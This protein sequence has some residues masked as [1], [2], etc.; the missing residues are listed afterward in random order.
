MGRQSAR[1]LNNK[2]DHKDIFFNGNYHTQMWVTD[3]EANPTLVWEKIQGEVYKGLEL[4]AYVNYSNSVFMFQAK[5]NF[6]VNWGDGTVE[7]FN[8]TSLS[9]II[10]PYSIRAGQN[11]YYD[12]LV[13][14]DI[15]DLSFQSASRLSAVKN[16]LPPTLEKTDFTSMFSYLNTIDLTVNAD[17]FKYCGDVLIFDNCFYNSRLTDI[18]EGLFENCISAK[19]AKGCFQS[20]KITSIPDNFFSNLLGI[21]NLDSCFYG[22]S[23]LETVGTNV[24]KSCN[25]LKSIVNIFGFT[26]ITSLEEGIFDDLEELENAQK[27][28]FQCTKLESIPY[29]L[30][31][32]CKKLNDVYYAFYNCSAI[33]SKVPPLWEREWESINKYYGCYY[34]CTNAEN[35]NDIPWI[36]WS[37]EDN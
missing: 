32:K 30:F 21:E 10:H 25:A 4:V 14:G 36:G 12:V 19:S 17:L 31:D 20:T 27:M 23:S 29:S 24:F 8:K 1:L 9:Y 5:G 11:L 26:N 15:T 37:E 2:K 13:S 18:P 7:S 22:C 28:C 3:E 16:A 34:N 6:T 33:T 35:R